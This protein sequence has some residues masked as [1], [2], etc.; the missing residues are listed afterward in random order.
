VARSGRDTATTKG[1]RVEVQVVSG[2]EQWANAIVELGP[3]GPLPERCVIVPNA[4]VA[5]ALVRTFHARDERAALL[6]TR[7]VTLQELARE[8][9]LDGGEK[10]TLRSATLTELLVRDAI[11]QLDFEHFDDDALFAS[12]AAEQLAHTLDELASAGF[13]A[14]RLMERVE[15]KLRDLGRIASLLDAS[16]TTSKDAL[17]ERAEKRARTLEGRP[18]TLAVVTGH[19]SVAEAALLRALPNLTLLVWA[20]SLP[21][22]SARLQVLFG[23]TPVQQASDA[24]GSEPLPNGQ[25]LEARRRPEL[26]CRVSVASHEGLDGELDAALAWARALVAE[27]GYA[28][29]DI[30]MLA[31]LR[32]PYGAL[33]RA[34]LRATD[35]PWRLPVRYEG[36]V[37]LDESGDGARLARVVAALREGIPAQRLATLLPDLRSTLQSGP[38]DAASARALLR[39]VDAR[40]GEPADLRAGRAW[41]E[42]W[43]EAVLRIERESRALRGRER[44]NK[45]ALQSELASRAHAI[46][47]LTDVLRHVIA[48]APLGMVWMC[49]STFAGTQLRR[50]PGT[51]TLAIM[52]RAVAAFEGHEEH[53]PC[54]EAALTWIA[55]TLATSTRSE[56]STG[57][58]LYFGSVED[59]RAL[60]FRAV[61]IL[62]LS[63]QSFVAGDRET[64]LLSDAERRSLSPLLV[65]QR[66]RLRRRE[67]ALVE[68]MAMAREQVVL[69][70][71]C[72]LEA[73]PD[74][75]HALFRSHVAQTERAPRPMGAR[76]ERPRSTAA[77][78]LCTDSGHGSARAASR[79]PSARTPLR[80][81][82]PGATLADE[83]GSATSHEAPEAVAFDATVRRALALMLMKRANNPDGATR[84]AARASGLEARVAV[85][86]DHVGRAYDALASA[87]LLELPL[88]LAYQLPDEHGWGSSACDVVVA[89]PRALVAIA[90]VTNGANAEGSHAAR[91]HARALAHVSAGLR[92]R[93]ASLSSHDGSLHWLE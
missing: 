8:L 55:R 57:D 59:A 13:G 78:S 60:S 34:R 23:V 89:T 9:L 17:L 35:G 76:D 15:P 24:D 68:A 5:A 30:A 73:S 16:E 83:D 7:F 85:A 51:A 25:R 82:P 65:T 20:R 21:E 56:R 90:L 71:P 33:L 69:S 3:R 6:G 70:A 50:A 28:P 49:L 67:A 43:E 87:G 93:A 10:A 11:E 1:A 42:A 31:P 41:P 77:R 58:A 27:H 92:V 64:T 46:E 44:A 86:T 47:A 12:D 61:R 36:G 39:E 62:G 38:L 91:A 22:S 4:R 53:E 66:Q 63:E 81:L 37:P 18:P 2:L 75:P 45:R 19:E 48:G 26:R 88:R 54:G 40:G 32:E 14:A 29:G 72:T 52:E 79:G 80:K 74:R 84:L